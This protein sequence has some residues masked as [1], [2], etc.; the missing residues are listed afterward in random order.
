MKISARNQFK[1]TIKSINSSNVSS[2]IDI[3][4]KDAILISSLIS[5]DAVLDLDLKVGEKVI[6]FFKSTSIKLET[7]LENIKKDIKYFKGY[8]ENIYLNKYSINL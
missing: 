7:N 2:K 4:I 5:N 6:S 1:G 3:L 8:M